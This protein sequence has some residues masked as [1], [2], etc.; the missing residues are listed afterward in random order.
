LQCPELDEKTMDN[1]RFAIETDAMLLQQFHNMG[2][3][4]IITWVLKENH[5]ARN[6]MS[7]LALLRPVI[8]KQMNIVKKL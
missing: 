5:Q 3:S 1:I 7:T 4:E 2:F 8:S 6:F